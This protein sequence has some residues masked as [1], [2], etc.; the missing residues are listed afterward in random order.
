MTF[1]KLRIR[2]LFSS[3]RLRRRAETKRTALKRSHSSAVFSPGRGDVFFSNGYFFVEFGPLL[4]T[5]GMPAEE[6]PTLAIFF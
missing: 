6:V 4:E 5:W 3:F 2:A 1:E